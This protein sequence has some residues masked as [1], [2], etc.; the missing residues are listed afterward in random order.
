PAAR[1]LETKPPGLRVLANGHE[2][3]TL[4]QTGPGP[5]EI[6]FVVPEAAVLELQ[7]VL[8]GV[9]L[10]NALAWLGRVTGLALWHRFRA[11][12]T[13]RR[14]RLA[15]IT[16]ASGEPI[17]DFAQRDAPYS[18][19]YARRHVQLGLNVVGFLTAD[20]GVGESARC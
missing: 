14:L 18:A 6:R 12:N 7:F 9:R 13:V 2:V 5:W 20:L 11:Q 10:S 1:G 17:F 19:A 16:T 4:R 8:T 15:F 3:A